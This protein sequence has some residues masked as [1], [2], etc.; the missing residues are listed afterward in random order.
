MDFYRP[1]V[2]CIFKGINVQIVALATFHNYF[3]G[4]QL[5]FKTQPLYI[6]FVLVLGYYLR[7]GNYFKFV[8]LN[9]K[10]FACCFA[11]IFQN[12]IKQNCIHNF[13]KTKYGL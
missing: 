10:F 6:V 1:E 13:V 4:S 9:K 7:P 11:F 3:D 12:S 2:L 5:L 8:N